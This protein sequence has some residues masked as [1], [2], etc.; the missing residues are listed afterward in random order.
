MQVKTHGSDVATPPVWPLALSMLR[1]EGALIFFSGLGPALLM[2]PAAMAQYTLMDPLRSMMP[3]HVAAVI[4][5]TIDI[6]IKCPFERVK[7]QMQ[8]GEAHSMTT[9]IRTTFATNGVIGLW[10]G[11][12]A[13]LT[14][15]IPYLV[16][17]WLTYSQA[18][19]FLGSVIKSATAANLIAGAVAGA[20]A[21]TAVTPADV[22]KTRQQT[23]G[24]G[25]GSKRGVI[26]VGRE[27]IHEGGL[28][29]LFRGLGPR[30]MRIPIY[31]AITL[32]TFDF[33]KDV[34]LATNTLGVTDLH[35]GEL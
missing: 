18:Q 30:L 33:V 27:L 35:R 14:R 29:S 25:P 10:A 3:L 17:K 1:N 20:V 2:A 9:L 11:L 5:G 12:G 21:A 34:F 13:T 28:S 31:T 32:A 19:T 26:A 22:I 24:T 15:D 16:L 7:T 8:G 4:A 23:S 6:L